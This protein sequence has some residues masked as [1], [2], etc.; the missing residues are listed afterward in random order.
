MN[1][2]NI[3]ISN[4]SSVLEKSVCWNFVKRLFLPIFGLTV[5]M[6]DNI[7]NG[8]STFKKPQFIGF[9][10]ISMVLTNLLLVY[11]FEFSV[12]IEWIIF[13]FL[14]ILVFLPW[15]FCKQDFSSIT[16]NSLFIKQFLKNE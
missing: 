2:R 3:R 13:R 15:I 12:K 8:F 16:K 4:R 14:I 11:I 5:K 9:V 10:V 1:K 7:K 6:V